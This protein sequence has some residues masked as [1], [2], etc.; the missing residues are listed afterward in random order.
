M[1]ILKKFTIDNKSY[2]EKFANILLKITC[3]D[4]NMNRNV[5]NLYYYTKLFSNSPFFS[6][7]HDLEKYNKIILLIKS[8]FDKNVKVLNLFL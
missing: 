3:E 5:K 2:T 4:L 6:P 7:I 8:L 1:K